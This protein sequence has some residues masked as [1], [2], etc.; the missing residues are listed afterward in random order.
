VYQNQKKKKPYEDLSLLEG[1]EEERTATIT[2]LSL[3]LWFMGSSGL[4]CS[5][6]LWFT[7]V[8]QC[9]WLW[10]LVWDSDEEQWLCI[11]SDEK[12]WLCVDPEEVLCVDLEVVL[13]VDSEV[14]IERVQFLGAV[15]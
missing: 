11:D 4:T 14:E 15:P 7:S 2:S 6:M 12:L 13:C 1:E 3:H 5:V 9:L 10:S 8:G